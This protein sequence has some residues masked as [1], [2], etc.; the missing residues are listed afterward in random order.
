MKRVFLA[1]D[2]AL[3][4]PMLVTLELAYDARVGWMLMLGR[5]HAL[6]VLRET[7]RFQVPLLEIG[8]VSARRSGP[9]AR[10]SGEVI[11]V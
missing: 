3:C 2:D 11:H 6:D 8:L 5:E 9:S 1:R 10:V 7:P 4:R